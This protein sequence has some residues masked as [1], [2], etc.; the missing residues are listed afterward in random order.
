MT[1]DFNKA[2]SACA[3][4]FSNQYQRFRQ[5]NPIS[6]I[7][8]TIFAILTVFVI[9]GRITDV[10]RHRYVDNSQQDLL[11]SMMACYVIPLFCSYRT[12]PEISA[13][14]IADTAIW[15]QLAVELVWLVT[16]STGWSFGGLNKS[17]SATRALSKLPPA[18]HSL[19]FPN[20]A[21][22]QPKPSYPRITSLYIYQHF[23]F[24]ILQLS[25]LSSL[26]LTL[27]SFP[28]HIRFY[29]VENQTPRHQIDPHCP[30]NQL[31]RSSFTFTHLARFKFP[32]PSP[33]H[34]RP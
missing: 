25:R 13:V 6:T 24:P 19:R 1:Y 28:A 18:A 21:T 9:G 30:K 11:S 32:L 7:N 23:P 34:Q 15:R 3:Q 22:N 4:G 14:E 2:Q 16:F 17:L 12:I 20:D 27:F 29:H 10:R 26:S 8:V 31:Q 33:L 5:V